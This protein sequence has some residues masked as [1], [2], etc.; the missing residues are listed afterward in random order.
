MNEIKDTNGKFLLLD[1]KLSDRNIILVALYGPNDD[2]P[3][4]FNNI[5][6]KLESLDNHSISICGD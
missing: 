5:R 4:F 1:I 2:T 3:V 6:R